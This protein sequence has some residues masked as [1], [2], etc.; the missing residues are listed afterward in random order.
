MSRETENT[1]LLLVGIGVGLITWSGT[2][3]RYVKPGLLPWLS[4]SAVLLVALAT[5]SI[6]GDL[7]RGGPRADD[8]GHVHRLTFFFYGAH[9]RVHSDQ[10]CAQ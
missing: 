9:K 2:F 4:V 5:A 7:R 8:H 3:T 6:I 10:T 1:I